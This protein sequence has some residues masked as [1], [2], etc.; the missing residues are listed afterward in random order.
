MRSQSRPS[1][2]LS[3]LLLCALLLPGATLAQTQEDCEVAFNIVHCKIGNANL[4]VTPSGSLHVTNLGSSGDDGFTS[5]FDTASHWRAQL[6]VGEPASSL[7]FHALLDGATTAS[8]SFRIEPGT[9]PVVDLRTSFTGAAGPHTY[10]MI[11]LDDGEVVADVGGLDE[12]SS[13]TIGRIPT[14]E[15]IPWPGPWPWPDFKRLP[16]G[17]CAWQFSYS[18]GVTFTTSNGDQAIG[19]TVRLVEDVDKAHYLYAGFTAI[20]TQ[21]D[22]NSLTITN[23]QIFN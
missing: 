15:P 16:S 12:S 10:R 21:S 8:A 6:S 22:A 11:V 7:D 19:D 2:V 13:I 3:V 5:E 20:T 1:I 9:N 18:G 17:A 4:Q 14:P 23:E